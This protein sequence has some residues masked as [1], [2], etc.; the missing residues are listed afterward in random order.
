MADEQQQH[1]AGGLHPALRPPV[2]AL[3]LPALHVRLRPRR[4]HRHHRQLRYAGGV[5]P[6]AAVPRPD[7]LPDGQPGFLR[8]HQVRLR[9]AH[10]AGQP[11]HQ[12]LALRLLPLLLPSH[13][14]EFPHPRLY[15]DVPHDRH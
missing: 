4:C 12:Q 8:P 11:P 2:R 14:A 7:L 5:G 6:P 10:H 3:R 1:G 15:A 13:D 9:A